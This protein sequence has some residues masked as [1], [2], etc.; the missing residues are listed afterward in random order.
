M[1]EPCLASI[2]LTLFLFFFLINE[3]LYFGAHHTLALNEECN[4]SA[5]IL[6][7]GFSISAFN[8]VWYLLTLSTAFKTMCGDLWFLNVF[9]T[10][11]LFPFLS[12]ELL[13]YGLLRRGGW[14][15]GSAGRGA[16]CQACQPELKLWGLRGGRELTSESHL[17]T[18][19][20]VPHPPQIKII[21]LAMDKLPHVPFHRS[22]IS[23]TPL[24]P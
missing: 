7:H 8:D 5:F 15:D 23:L 21:T 19:I 17:L 2:Y 20:C 11:F 9:W 13:F 12:T 14:Q 22:R 24:S 10:S 1:L 3:T 6:G 18:F 16:C 4:H